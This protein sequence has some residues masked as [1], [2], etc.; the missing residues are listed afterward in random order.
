MERIEAE[1]TEREVAYGFEFWNQP[2]ASVDADVALKFG[3]SISLKLAR[4]ALLLSGGVV[5][6][7]L[8]ISISTYRN[9]EENERSGA[10]TL[11]SLQKAADVIGCEMVYVIR[12]KNHATFIARIWQPLLAEA[13]FHPWMRKCD[14]RKKAGAL[15]SIVNTLF[16]RPSFRRKMEWRRLRPGEQTLDR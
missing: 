1:L 6:R 15:G 9:I 7:R 11:R 16:E 5:A 3:K 12:P 4:E 10:V 13:K 8:G 2:K 14:Q